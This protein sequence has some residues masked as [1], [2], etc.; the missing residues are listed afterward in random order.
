MSRIR[1]NTITDMAGTG[2][3]SFTNG[4]YSAGDVGIG[5]N[6]PSSD[7]GTNLSVHSTAT[8]GAR[9]KI[10]DGTTGKGNLDGL[11][12]ISTGGVAYFINRET[13]DMSFSA[14]AGEK[15][16]I[17]SG[18]L[19]D[20]SGGVQISENVTPTTGSGVEIFKASST[21]GQIQVFNR[22]SSAWMDLALKGKEQI[23][24]TAGTERV[25]IDSSGNVVIGATSGQGLFSVHQSTSATSNY[26]NIT[27]NATGTPSWSNGMLLG[28]NT[29]GDALCWQNENLSLVFG[30]NNI[31][32]M[33]ILSGGGLTFNGDTAAANALDDYEEGTWTPTLT[34]V[35]IG[36]GTITGQYTKIGN[37]I[38]VTFRLEGGSTTTSSSMTGISG[39]PFTNALASNTGYL[40]A[41]NTSNNWFGYTQQ[42]ST[43]T[44]TNYI[45]W[46]TGGSI[47]DIGNTNIPFTWGASTFMRFNMTYRVA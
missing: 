1:A 32:R 30:T 12:I 10:S 38:H 43:G 28:N 37:I 40:S 6:A 44:I 5:D 14:G 34:N 26:I 21:V 33:R 42:Y 9:L 41:S 13:A 25:R 46:V 35:T 3:P 11:D 18:G 20:I 39:L 22:D 16:R 8:D 24:Y 27:N 23:F 17:T 7:Y 2:K 36:N 45:Q 29:A 19:I 31:E 47:Q 4:L 15:L